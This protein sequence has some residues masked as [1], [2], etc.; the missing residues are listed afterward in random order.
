M[1]TYFLVRPVVMK[2]L[3]QV[4]ADC[5]DEMASMEALINRH[6]QLGNV[7]QCRCVMLELVLSDVISI[8]G[9]IQGLEHFVDGKQ[10]IGVLVYWPGSETRQELEQT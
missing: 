2:D 10:N 7:V 8:H 5:C 1:K 9:I 6:E 4:R 3:R